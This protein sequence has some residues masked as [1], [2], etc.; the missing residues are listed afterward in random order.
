MANLS[1][2]QSERRCRQAQGCAQYLPHGRYRYIFR[3]G[4]HRGDSRAENRPGAGRRPLHHE[5][6]DGGA[7]GQAFLQFR[8]R[9]PCHYGTFDLLDQ[10]PGAFVAAMAGHATKVA[11]LGIGEALVV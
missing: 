7:R 4:S 3:H 10:D 9:G 11:V 6:P 1:T 8:D 2:R 5:R